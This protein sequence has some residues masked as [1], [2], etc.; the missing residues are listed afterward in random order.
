MMFRLMCCEA[1]AAHRAF[2][3]SE[4]EA[5]RNLIVFFIECYQRWISPIKG[6]HCAHHA[7][8]RAETCSNAVKRLVKEHGLV[9][10][11]P[12]IRQ[13]FDECRAA[14]ELVSARGSQYPRADIPCVLPCDVAVGDCGL[15]AG[16]DAA[17][18][19]G[20]LYLFDEKLSKK[21][22]RFMAAL[23]LVA[24]LVATYWFYGH[25]VATI[26]VTDLGRD[27]QGLVTKLLKREQP[28]IR[29]LLM[30]NGRKYYS[31]IVQI[32]GSEREYKLSFG[33]APD[34]FEIDQ[35]K[36]LDARIKTNSELLVVGQILE[37]FPNPQKS[38]RGE[39]FS[40]RLKRRWSLF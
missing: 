16:T 3:D 4:E 21:T 9:K 12:F 31:N 18:S 26:Y 37:D 39:R 28:E 1:T 20:D 33:A 8:H 30:V 11:R 15:S 5:V 23:V 32:D 38:D 10:A 24:I 17:C 7:V 22:K 34:N 14:G 6:F 2:N 35:L 25:K 27:G 13:R 19:C 36:I 29:V 40:Y